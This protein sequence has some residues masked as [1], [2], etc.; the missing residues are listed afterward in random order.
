MEEAAAEA[1]KGRGR[2]VKENSLRRRVEKKKKLQCLLRL[3]FLRPT[4]TPSAP[5]PRPAPLSR[6]C[7]HLTGLLPQL[8]LQ[9]RQRVGEE[10]KEE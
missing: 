5:R 2:I 4:P 8:L 1:G 3:L 10:E 6:V 7:T 9:P